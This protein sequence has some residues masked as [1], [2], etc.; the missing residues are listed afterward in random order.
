ME[1][2]KKRPGI[3]TQV[4]LGFA[5][6]TAVTVALLWIFQIALLNAFYRAIKTAEISR[7]ADRVSSVRSS[8]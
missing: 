4:F 5:A 3:R 7:V 1:R 2:R 8:P 6:F